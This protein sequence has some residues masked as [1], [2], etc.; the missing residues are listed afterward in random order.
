MLLEIAKL[1]TEQREALAGFILTFPRSKPEVIA[2]QLELRLAQPRFEAN[3]KLMELNTDYSLSGA[4]LTLEDPAAA[5]GHSAVP[6]VPPAPPAAA[7]VSTA[8]PHLVIPGPVVPGSSLL[9]KSGLPWDERIHAGSKTTTADELWRKKRG[10]ADTLVTTVEAE[11]R[12]LMNIPAP[13]APAI[14]T[15]RMSKAVDPLDCSAWVPPAVPAAPAAAIIAAPPP[16]PAAPIVD[17]R[18]AFVNLIGK[19]SAAIQGQKLTQEELNAACI[20]VGV[21]SLPLLANRLDL[22]PQVEALINSTIASR[23]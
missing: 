23:P 15:P 2:E 16:P 5:F 18:Q 11:L 13:A 14:S 7:T 12:A 10:V 21:P 8:G 22:V 3:G 19:A 9:D 17:D 1:S 20:A 6:A 4:T